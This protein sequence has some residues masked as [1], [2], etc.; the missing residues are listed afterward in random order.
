VCVC[1]VC[2]VVCVSVWCGVNKGGVCVCGVCDVVCV[3]VWYVCMRVV[4][5]CV[6]YVVWYV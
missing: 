3:C 1:G 4:C 2:D 5:V 6:V